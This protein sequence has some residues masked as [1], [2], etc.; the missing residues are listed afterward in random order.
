MYQTT[1]KGKISPE[2]IARLDA[3][4]F[5][6]D[7]QRARWNIMYQKLLQFCNE[8]GHCR[9]PKGYHRDTELAN[10]VRNQRLEYANLIKVNKILIIVRDQTLYY[11]VIHFPN[12]IIPKIY[13]N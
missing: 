3:I 7:P 1:G 2:R 13:Q 5:E 12:L 8:H 11:I 10:W 4:G 9:V 6:W